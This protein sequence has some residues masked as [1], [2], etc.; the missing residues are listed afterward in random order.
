MIFLIALAHGLVVWIVSVTTKSRRQTIIAA[1]LSAVVGGVTGNPAYILIDVVSVI[2]ALLVSLKELERGRQRTR[3][4]EERARLAAEHKS[5]QRAQMAAAF[6]RALTTLRHLNPK[7]AA[8][9]EQAHREA[10]AH[11]PGREELIFR[12]AA[13][14]AARARGLAELAK[15]F[16]KKGLL[17]PDSERP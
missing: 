4:A 13:A 7:R 8:A 12:R 1:I 3:A 17:P 9:W 2:I 11:N 16:K 10:A 5:E 14:D 15:E 6:E